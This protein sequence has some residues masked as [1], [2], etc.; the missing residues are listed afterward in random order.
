M[1]KDKSI[2]EKLTATYGVNGGLMQKDIEGIVIKSLNASPCFP[3]AKKET[4]AS[5][6]VRVNDVPKSRR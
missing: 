4:P 6:K 5:F 3:L 2:A 1:K